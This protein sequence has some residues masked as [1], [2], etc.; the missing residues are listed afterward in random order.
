[1]ASIVPLTSKKNGT[2]FKAVIRIKGHKPVTKTL[3][4]RT[5]AKRWA[6]ATETE[7][8]EG[9]YLSGPERTVADVLDTYCA[10]TLTGEKK[11]HAPWRRYS[12]WWKGRIGHKRLVALTPEDVADGLQALR[13]GDTLSG[14]PAKQATVRQYFLP[15]SR[16]INLAKGWGWI[17]VSPLDGLERPKKAKGRAVEVPTSAELERLFDACRA[18]DGR[19]RLE[20]LARMAVATAG[21]QNELMSLR[22]RD[23]DLENGWARLLQT[24]GDKPRTVPV[25]GEALEL[26]R[27][28]CPDAEGAEDLPVFGRSTFPRRSWVA[29]REAA[30]MSD[31]H[32]HDLRHW[33]ASL[34]AISGATLRQLVDLLGHADISQV[35]RYAHLCEG[36]HLGAIADRIAKAA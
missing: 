13:F 4:T 32:F 16:A 12:G 11:W 1:M 21:R 24:K 18:A 29:A 22:W 10:H 5:A 9:R 15:L 2:R 7:I 8:R 28:R 26:A 14:K 20:F 36:G 35:M 31:L 30:G 33:A 25:R 23:L 6:A 19:G 3:G 27:Q 34:F 17:K